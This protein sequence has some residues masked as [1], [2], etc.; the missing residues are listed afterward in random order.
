MA[1]QKIAG[2][3][4][5]HGPFV[6]WHSAAVALGCE[7]GYNTTIAL[8]IGVSLMSARARW[9][10]IVTLLCGVATAHAREISDGHSWTI[11]R[12]DSYGFSISYP[13]DVFQ[14][15]RGSEVRDGQSFV[16]LDG[17][18]RVLFGTWRNTGRLEPA[19]YRDHFAKRS[20]KGFSVRYRRLSENRFVLTGQG[21]GKRFYEKVTFSCQGRLISSVAMIYPS[22]RREVY[23]RIIGGMEKSFQPGSVEGCKPQTH[24]Q[25][26]QSRKAPGLPGGRQTARSRMR[27]VPVTR[28][29]RDDA[30]MAHGY[31]RPYMGR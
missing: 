30:K 11:Y 22:E 29:R 10:L 6:G 13:A 23:E 14:V 12:N 5:E 3:R 20:Y 27:D 25:A 31:G 28:N 7:Q 4:S 8:G 24:S 21:D 26:R 17:E 18:A 15:E 9:S 2:S 16:S 1:N 19:A